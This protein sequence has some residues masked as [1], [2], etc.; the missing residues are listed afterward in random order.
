MAAQEESISR[1]IAGYQGYF[2]R[3]V[4]D[5]DP[6]LTHVGPGTAMG[7][8]LRRFWQP[9]CMSEDLRDLPRSIRIMGEDLVAF[10]DK[11][12]QF[13]VLQRHCSHRGTSLEYGIVAERGIR[14]CY[15]GWLFDAD[16]TI[17]ET[18]GEPP[19]SKLKESFRHGAYP[20]HEQGGLVFAYMGPS[21]YQP[22]F[23]KFDGYDLWDTRMKSFEVP[24]SCNWLQ[25][26]DNY[27]DPAHSQFLHNSFASI[28]FSES[29]GLKPYIQF[30][31]TPDGSG[32]THNTTRRTTDEL[33]W[34]QMNHAV[35]PNIGEISSAW[36]KGHEPVL[37]RRVY[38]TRWTVPVD[39]TNTIM[40]GWRHLNDFI[41]PWG[42]TDESQIGKNMIDFDGQSARPSYE[43]G[44]RDPGDWEAWTGQR[45]I[46]IH[47]K[48]NLGSTDSGVQARR[49]MLRQA[50]RGE[51]PDLYPGGKSKDGR[52]IRTF[53][54]GAVL[55]V[56]K[57][58]DPQ[59]DWE[60]L[61][62]VGRRV[63]K[64]IESGDHLLGMERQAFIENRMAEIESEL[65]G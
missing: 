13:G 33:V 44:Q 14:C 47:A 1:P 30:F 46:A 34:T 42:T 10:R 60:L 58:P 41:D 32:L 9:V 39:D 19:N 27:V 48:E 57:Q 51:R 45:P 59:A 22:D 29:F 3:D 23:P 2:L 4:P 54:G 28:H 62:E 50:L 7:E 61:G 55:K 16:G 35:T 65:G 5:E 36:E 25:V 18:P 26:T 11:S 6:E 64:A 15:H 43:A 63:H 38:G 52:P 53:S 17:L 12:G 21:E 31:E 20:A 56:A 37:F 24:I 8:Y 40:F 49:L